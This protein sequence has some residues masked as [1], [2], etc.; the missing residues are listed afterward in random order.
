MNPAGLLQRFLRERSLAAVPPPV[1]LM[2]FA[3]LA[4]QIAWHGAQSLRVT[5]RALPPAPPAAAVRALSFGEAPV[6]SR[7]LMLWLQAYDDQPGVS[8][9]FQDLDYARVISW[10]ELILS[11][12]PRGQYPLLAASRVYG[13][14]HNP[15]KQRQM[16]AFVYDKFLE[17]PERRWPWLAHAVYLSK[18]RLKDLPLA[19][20]YARA[21]REHAAGP[22]VPHW[23][24]Q[25]EI[26]VLEEIG[27]LEAARIIVG[28]LLESGK[29]TDPAELRLLQKR[30][31]E[32]E[33]KLGNAG[34]DTRR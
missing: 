13:E 18:H 17:D 23:A 25:L 4:A 14:V 16:L 28:G 34:L 24:Q 8:I 33:A 11:L 19:L 5:V 27:E 22:E 20:H 12:D 31:E 7:L 15:D 6:V 21:L 1:M 26:F 29:I 9:S 30:L 32:L 3:A 2:L 10:L